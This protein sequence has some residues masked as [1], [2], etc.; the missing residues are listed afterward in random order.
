[1][2]GQKA[3]AFTA[4]KGKCFKVHGPKEAQQ[5]LS[6]PELAERV[7]GSRW[8]LTEKEPEQKFAVAKTAAWLQRRPK[9]SAVVDRAGAP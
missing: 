8:V 9:Q 6:R 2:C 4:A 3:E 1:M 5:I 7:M